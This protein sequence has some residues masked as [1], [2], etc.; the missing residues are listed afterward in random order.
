[1]NNVCFEIIK[2]KSNANVS[3]ETMITAVKSM[4]KDLASCEG[5][6]QQTLYKNSNDEWVDIYYWTNDA[7]AHASNEFMADKESFSVLM[8]LIEPSSVSL[9][10]LSALQSS[11][12]VKLN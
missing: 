9:E 3:D 8:S 6:L 11:G 7:C 12:N 4:E 2:W 10:V 5:F 1:M